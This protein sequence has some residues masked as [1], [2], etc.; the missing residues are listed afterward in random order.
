MLCAASPGRDA[1]YGDSGGPLID[2]NFN[3]QV[4]LVSFGDSCAKQGFPGVYS[5]ISDQWSWIYR[6]ICDNHSSPKP[7]MCLAP[8]VSPTKRP[9]AVP[10]VS[11]NPPSPQSPVAPSRDCPSD[12]NRLMLR[13]KTDN[14]GENTFYYLTK[15]SGGPA[16]ALEGNSSYFQNNTLYARLI[17]LSQACCYKFFMN[18]KSGSG[19]CCENGDGWYELVFNG[20]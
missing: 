14:A 1:C 8:N 5:R 10:P 2:S 9:I 7:S 19:M 6:T 17:C 13:F 12:R 4:G 11:V 15:N 3:V 18:N 20:E 16:I